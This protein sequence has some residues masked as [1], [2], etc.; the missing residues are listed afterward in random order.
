[1]RGFREKGARVSAVSDGCE[2]VKQDRNCR[3]EERRGRRGGT[4]CEVL[5]ELRKD[6]GAKRG[7]LLEIYE[8]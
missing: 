8:R 1:M 6:E 4:E 5:R 2:G 3:T 7:W